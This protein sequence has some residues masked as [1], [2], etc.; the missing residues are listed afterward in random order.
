MIEKATTPDH[1][2]VHRMHES[3]N[4]LNAVRYLQECC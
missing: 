3:E 4:L 1:T 2:R